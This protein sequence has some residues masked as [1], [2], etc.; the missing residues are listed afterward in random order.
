MDRYVTGSVI[1]R[2][3][4]ERGMT[5]A[6]LAEKLRVSDK[7]VSKWETGKGYPDITLLEPIAGTLGVSLTELF[8]GNDVTNRNRAGNM[9]RTKLYVCP[10]CGNVIV[11]SGEAVI[12][13][14]GL[15]LPAAEPEEPDE[16]HT[17]TVEKVEDEYYLTVKHDMTRE[18][19]ISFFLTLRDDR[20]QLIK[21]YPQGEAAARIDRSVR[22]VYYY[23]NRHGLY[24]KAVK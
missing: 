10:I 14:C 6:M 13:C 4:E 22:Y 16:A 15:T 1:R 21:L 8:S 12:S 19:Y 9:L 24:R 18:H 20:A 5:Q 7:T 23:C 11:S 2:L 17:L 3:R